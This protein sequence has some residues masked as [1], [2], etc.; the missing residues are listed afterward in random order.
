MSNLAELR[1]TPFQGGLCRAHP[2]GQY[3]FGHY[4][5]R[6]SSALISVLEHASLQLEVCDLTS[7]T[8]E[9]LPEGWLLSRP[10]I[11]ELRVPIDFDIGPVT[12]DVLPNLQTV[13]VDDLDIVTSLVVGRPVEFVQVRVNARRQTAFDKLIPILVKGSTK[14]VKTLYFL[15]D[16]QSI[17]IPHFVKSI[18]QTIKTLEV[19]R[20]ELIWVNYQPLR[21][22]LQ[23]G[24]TNYFR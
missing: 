3:G 6:R 24:S 22:V 18:A 8:G 13:F 12:T 10:G 11:T 17:D 2:T 1:F 4:G 7:I 16:L 5:A 21:H 9:R 20:F 15:V 14:P 23:V 19:L